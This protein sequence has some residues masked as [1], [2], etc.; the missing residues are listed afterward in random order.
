MPEVE[1]EGE[2]DEEVDA[3]SATEARLGTALPRR[4]LRLGFGGARSL[5]GDELGVGHQRR[6]RSHLMHC[7]VS[8]H[9]VVAVGELV[10]VLEDAQL[11]E[12]STGDVLGVSERERPEASV[13][14]SENGVP[15]GALYRLLNCGLCIKP[16]HLFS[17]ALLELGIWGLVLL[18]LMCRDYIMCRE[19]VDLHRRQRL[20]PLN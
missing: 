5:E 10:L 18:Y 17:L 13:C 11:V 2:C 6:A 19:L 9:L 1:L 14:A 3:E 16:M 8:P 15:V 7:A 12:E 20:I 4:V